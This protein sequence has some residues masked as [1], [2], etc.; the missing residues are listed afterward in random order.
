MNEYNLNTYKIKLNKVSIIYAEIISDNT[1]RGT[2][3]F[4]SSD[5]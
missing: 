2:D 4:G 3:G 1:T 5:S